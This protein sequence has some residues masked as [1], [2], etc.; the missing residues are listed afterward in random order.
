MVG[1]HKLCRAVKGEAV[2]VIEM[3]SADL[4]HMGD[5]FEDLLFVMKKFFSFLLRCYCATLK[6]T[7][8]FQK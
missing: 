4:V 1:K 2:E 6:I 8:D 3:I 7:L 5:L